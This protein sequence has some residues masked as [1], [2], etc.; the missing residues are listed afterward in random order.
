MKVPISNNAL[1]VIDEEEQSA[2]D[3]QFDEENPFQPADDLEFQK[4]YLSEERGNHQI[5]MI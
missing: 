4:N 3:S 5:E 2:I 1:D